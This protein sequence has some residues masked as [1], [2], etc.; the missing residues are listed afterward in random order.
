MCGDMETW[1]DMAGEC[2]SRIGIAKANAIELWRIFSLN[3]K[4]GVDS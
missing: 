1:Y 4:R 2:V 3:Q